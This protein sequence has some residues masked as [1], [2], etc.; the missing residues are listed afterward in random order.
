MMGVV[1]RDDE[2]RDLSGALDDVLRSLEGGRRRSGPG[3]PALGGLFG[4]WVEIV[5]EAVARQVEP[6]RLDGDRL[7]VQVT[8]PAW[9]TQVRLLS[10]R[11]TARIFEV[12]GVTVTQLDVRVG[13][14]RRR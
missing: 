4:R 2:P 6:I 7:V 10:D 13:P 1:R 12:V 5:G 11:I 3:A 8:E 14:P 9:A